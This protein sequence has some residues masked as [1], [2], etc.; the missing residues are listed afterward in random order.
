MFQIRFTCSQT[1]S[2]IALLPAQGQ[3][4]LA[5]LRLFKFTGK[6]TDWLTFIERFSDQIQNKTKLTDSDRMTY[7]FQNL[8]GEAKRAVESLGVTG[9]SD[10]AAPKSLLKRLFGNPEKVASASNDFK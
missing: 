5:P 2:S 1:D 7:L 4:R 8:D 10:S 3:Q 9:H 6:P